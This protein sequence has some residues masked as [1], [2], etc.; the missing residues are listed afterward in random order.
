MSADDGASKSVLVRCS[1]PTQASMSVIAFV[2]YEREIIIDTA[3]G[4]ITVLPLLTFSLGGH[5]SYKLAKAISYR[6]MVASYIGS[7]TNHIT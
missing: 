7:D 3:M 6:I 1:N 5:I 2:W 4:S